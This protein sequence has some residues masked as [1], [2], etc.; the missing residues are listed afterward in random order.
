MKT[1][2]GL[3]FGGTK[4]LIGEVDQNGNI[5]RERRYET[6]CRTEHQAMEVLVKSVW[7]YAETVGFAGEPAGA[8]VGIVGTVDYRKGKW[9]TMHPQAMVP[10]IP[11]TEIL[12]E[13]IHIPV[14]ADNDVKSAVTAEMVFGNGKNFDN[15]TYLNVGT[16]LAAGFVVDGRILRGKNNNSGEIGHTVV[17]MTNQDP[18]MCGRTGCIEN[19]VSG[20]G[21]TRQVTN[22]GLKELIP[23]KG[24]MTDVS[25][26][27]KKAA[28]GEK[29]PEKILDYAAENLACLI[30]NLV[31]TMDPEAFILGGGCVQDGSLLKRI[32]KKLVPTIMDSVTG[33][34]LLST[35]DPTHTGLLGAA[36]L[37]LAALRE[38]EAKS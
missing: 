1:Y 13:I 20:Y 4:L 22:Y 25:L 36:A 21:F 10:P 27:F 11:I 30:M 8:G 12:E 37:P 19:I 18:C 7:D 29:I 3:D 34:I 17:D 33:G 23:Q 28:A 5:L 9:I 31:K 15:F 6:G 32:E 14:W 16:G 24:D 38:Q 2:L 35:L 26:L